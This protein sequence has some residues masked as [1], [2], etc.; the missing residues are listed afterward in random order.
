MALK[1]PG[2]EEGKQYF[3]SRSDLHLSLLP[4]PRIE[5]VFLSQKL[6]VRGVSIGH[7]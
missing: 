1:S 6:A 7:L 2:G 5:I 4:H 3:K